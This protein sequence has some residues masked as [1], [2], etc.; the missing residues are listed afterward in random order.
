MLEPFLL[1][2]CFHVAGKGTFDSRN[3]KKHAAAREGHSITCNVL[4]ALLLLL[5]VLVCIIIMITIIIIISSSSS[6]SSSST[7]GCPMGCHHQTV[8]THNLFLRPISLL[9]LW[10]SEGS[11]Q[12]QS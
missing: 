11:T 10:I 12:A 2:P 6:S 4:Q 8:P 7:M 1:Q 5:C 9:T 3:N